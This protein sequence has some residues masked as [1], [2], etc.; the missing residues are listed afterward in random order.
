MYTG[1]NAVRHNTIIKIKNV[2]KNFDLENQT[3]RALIDINL[4]IFSCDFVLI[5][6]PSGCGK[7]TL[8]NVISGIEEPTDGKVMVRNRDIY[9]MPED[10]RGIF[11]SE[12]MGI[13]YQLPRWIKSFNTI[14]NIA[15]P[16]LVK[17]VRKKRAIERAMV[18]LEELKITNL[19]RQN[20]VQ[21]SG[22]EQQK[23]SFARALVSNP[24]IIIA[25]EPTG[26]LDSTSS[27]EV[28]AFFDVLNVRMKKTIILV[29]HNQAYWD[30]GT[31]RIEMKDG[32]IAREVGHG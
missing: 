31:R 19:A 2:N 18:V 16:L 30:L 3:K 26:N 8:L 13:I 24:R 20:P 27:D 22:G 15:M 11:R 32:L 1:D 28:M 23:V 10:I 12:K 25:D 7:S 6:G 14:E 9:S 21:L 5:Y 29:T 17:G 4:E